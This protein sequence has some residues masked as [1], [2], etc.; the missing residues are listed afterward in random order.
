M[1]ILT[2]PA[3]L[4]MTTQDIALR[5]KT[6]AAMVADGKHLSKHEL[7]ISEFGAWFEVYSC[8]RCN[9]AYNLYDPLFL[10]FRGRAGELASVDDDPILWRDADQLRL[11]PL[12]RPTYYSAGRVARCKDSE[13]CEQRQRNI[14]ATYVDQGGET[15]RGVALDQLTIGAMLAHDA[16]QKADLAMSL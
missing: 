5:E 9:R 4:R 15:R 1:S 2:E 11:D 6:L 10:A 16:G 12:G 3:R 8:A 14:Y 7:R 13:A